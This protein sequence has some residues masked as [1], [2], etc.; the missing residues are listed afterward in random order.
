MLLVT[1]KEEIKREYED[2][3]NNLY[4][5]LDEIK[6]RKNKKEMIDVDKMMADMG[7]NQYNSSLIG[8]HVPTKDSKIRHLQQQV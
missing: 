7:V 2:K 1:E 5:I 4:F 8:E 6:K 3:I